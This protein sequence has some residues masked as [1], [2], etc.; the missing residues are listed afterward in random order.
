MVFPM[1]QWTFEKWKRERN[2]LT[3][4]GIDEGQTLDEPF[5]YGLVK[6][7]TQCLDLL[8]IS[9]KAIETWLLRWVNRQPGIFAFKVNTVGIYDPVKKLYRKNWNPYI[10]KG[11]HDII[12]I[13]YG[14]FFSIE[15]K[16]SSGKLT[17]DQYL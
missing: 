2:R 13:C 17:Q 3:L 12:G 15:V 10:I 16:S 4:A 6:I 14:K 11:T 8:M 7:K 1:P 9:E 5:H